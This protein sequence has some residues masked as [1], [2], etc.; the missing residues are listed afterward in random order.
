MT[1]KVIDL[2]KKLKALADKGVGG[3][4]VKRCNCFRKADEKA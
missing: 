2:C 4:R 3:E 1:E